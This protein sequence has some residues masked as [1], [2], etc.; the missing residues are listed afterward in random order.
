M[1]KSVLIANRGEI[2]CRIA[3][4]ARRMGLRSIAV[5]SEADRHARH[6]HICDEAYAIGPSPAA[7]SYLAIDKLIACA[8]AARADCIHPGYGFLSENAEFAQACRDAGFVFVGPPV[9][10]IRAMGLKDRAKAI[11]EKAGVPVVPGYHGEMQEPKFLKQKAYEIGYPVLIKAVAGGGGKGMRRVD[12]HADFDSALEGAQREA[13]ASF[14]DG[15]VLIEKFVQSPRHIE[16]QIFADRHGNVIHL[17]ERDCSMQR[18]HQKVIEESPAPG[19]SA[20][21]RA[22]MGAAAV[23][24]AKAAGYVGAGTVEFIA[25]GSNGLNADGYWFMEMNT[26][27]Q[28]EHPV[29]EAITG[30]DLVEWQLR[31]AAGEKLPLAQ[32][33]A[34]FAGHAVE[35][36]LYAEDPERGFLPSTGRVIALEFPEAEGV[37]IDS[38]VETGGEVTQFYD[39]MIAKLIAHGSQRSE[40]LDRLA[41]AL[42]KTIVI[43]PRCNAR[44][45]AMLCR[46]PAFREGDFDTG[47]IDRNLTDLT[48]PQG[49]DRAAVALGAQE[50]LAHEQARIIETLKSAADEPASPWDVADGFQLSGARRLAIP[51]LAEGETVVAEVVYG[52]QGPVV[53]VDGISAAKDAVAVADRNVVYVLRHGRQ[54]RV[55]LRDAALDEAGDQDK[56]GLVRAPMHGKVLSL[57][58]EAGAHVVRGQRLAVIEAMKME[59]TLVAPIDGIVAEIA[60]AVDA[61]VA[62]GGKVM[63]IA[64]L[65]GSNE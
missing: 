36:R 41:D 65:Q 43:G 44:F 29:T 54:S 7:E 48:T 42:D 20:E 40:A 10:A 63:R 4:T 30:L 14:G 2:A 8:N 39:P 31:I 45:L 23:A 52:P 12:R 55:S 25:D 50:L 35:A 59:H 22:T 61:Q 47:L 9:D 51:I 24:A 37:R 60:V 57:L 53:S 26:R 19:M 64:P 1:F 27:L 49:L 32:H 21:L 18:R 13:K 62:E 16:L 56:S 38:G 5:Y 3:Q 6:V 15:R 11:M 46:S 28:V 34:K 58:V 17:G 33:Q